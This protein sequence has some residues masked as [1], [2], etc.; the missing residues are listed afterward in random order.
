MP[1][2]FVEMK[3]LKYTFKLPNLQVVDGDLIDNGFE[4]ETYTF[5]LLHKGVGLFEELSGTPL[6]AYL[7][8]ID[9]NNLKDSMSKLM[10]KDFIPNLA[11]ASYVKIEDNKFHNNRA[12][13]EDF[14]KLPV[15]NRINDDVEFAMELMQMALDC[16]VEVKKSEQK[17]KEIVNSKKV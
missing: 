1:P 17:T 12:T 6:M 13:A 16:M 9:I 8:D 7:V 2:L 3:I 4:E 15:F 14:K 11:C 10:S 5:T